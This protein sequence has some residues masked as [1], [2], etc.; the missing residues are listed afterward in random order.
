MRESSERASRSICL[1]Q[2][3]LVA[4]V[5]R[6]DRIDRQIQAAATGGMPGLH[7]AARPEAR[8]GA[9]GMRGFEQRGQHHFVGIREAGLLAGQRAHTDALLDAVRAVLDDAVLERPRLFTRRLE[10]DVGVVD[11]VTHHVAEHVGNAILVEFVPG[12]S[13]AVRA[14]SSGSRWPSAAASAAGCGAN[15]RRRECSVS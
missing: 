3:D 7:A 14:T 6:V 15:M 1:E 2:L 12:A 9:R 4:I 10:I 11:G 5:E 13:S 8:N